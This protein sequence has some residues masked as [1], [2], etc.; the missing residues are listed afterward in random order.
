[1]K[2]LQLIEASQ[3]APWSHVNAADLTTSVTVR[4]AQTDSLFEPT[5]PIRIGSFKYV[6]IVG[7]AG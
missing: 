2:L 3:I 6:A 7:S 5:K 4:A 1:M